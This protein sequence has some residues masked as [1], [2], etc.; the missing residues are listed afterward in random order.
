[1]DN[2]VNSSC[3]CELGYEKGVLKKTIENNIFTIYGN[4]NKSNY[5][6]LRYHGQLI[7]SIDHNN[8]KNNLYISYY[9]DDNINQN[10]VVSLAKCSK[11]IGEN[12][13]TLISLENYNSI[14]FN[15]F[16]LPEGKD[17]SSCYTE[18]TSFTLPI[19][20]NPLTNILQKYG[21]EDNNNLPITTNDKQIQIKFKK[22]ISWIKQL[23][24]IKNKE[25]Y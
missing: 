11:C 18:E 1:M 8:Y 15:F 22:L 4:I 2:N 7:D 23:F 5:I 13:C 12:Y 6:V 21:I 24:S 25:T 16:M 17:N 19:T 20:E 3:I 10:H 9:F 14:S